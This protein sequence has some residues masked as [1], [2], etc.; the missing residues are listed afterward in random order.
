MNSKNHPRQLC[1]LH[2]EDNENDHLLVVEALRA[3][4]LN[5]KF[6]LAKSKDE[7]TEAL[8]TAK[9]DLI[10]SDYALPSYDGASALS[11]ARSTQP[12]T[13]F[14]FLSG[15][16]GEEVAV[17]SLK[18]GA[19][20]YVLKQRPVRLIAAIHQALQNAAERVRLNQAEAVIR[21]QG[22]LLDKAQDAII[23][24][25]LE[26][27][28]IYWNQGA[29]RVY[30][31]SAAEA[32][33]KDL[34]D[35]LFHGD[36][37]PEA[38]D[39]AKHMDKGDEWTGE[40]PEFTKDGRTV[41]VQARATLIRD[42]QGRPK[43]LLIINTDITEKKN[44]EIQLLRSQR[45][46]SL[47]ALAG[48][49]AHD[50]NNALTPIIIG[51]QLLKENKSGVEQEK[52]LDMICASANRGAGMVRQILS[53]ARGSKSQTKQI[54][55]RQLIN[56]MIRIIRNTFPKS[57]L[58]SVRM[59]GGLWNVSGDVTELHQVIL[60]LCVNARDAMPQGGTLTLHAENQ[61]LNLETKSPPADMRPGSYVMLA[62]ADTGTGI[63]PEVLPRIFEPFFSTK[64]PDRGTGLGLSTVASIVKHHN[65]FIQVHSEVGHGTEFKIY[66]P[67]LPATE[68][69]SPPSETILPV[70]HGELIL[71]MDDEATVR[72][73]TKTTLENYGYQ[74]VTAISGLDG[75]TLFQE[76][77][78]EIKLL[79]S[80]TD[81]P[82]MSG[83]AALHIIQK[84][85]PEIPMI[86][87]S[88]GKQDPASYKQINATHLT[89]LDKPYTVEQL[90]QTVAR[91]LN[92]VQA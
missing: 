59:G 14:I 42:E 56:E 75:L 25:N 8:R 41:I 43:S 39:A 17:D 18:N 53:F 16:I 72:Q 89:V 35:L 24:C 45:M 5:C 78:Q 2:L 63:P 86:I 84:L 38:Q 92:S 67:A 48:G 37:P 79:V 34:R 65:G 82:I 46:D 58:T 49:I 70:G 27:L 50:L 81:M 26:R 87:A 71:V 1:V 47:G 44:Y 21:E 10:I 77:R 64:T 51:A 36:I 90:L 11:L 55:V 20:D 28:I 30:G 6:T 23:V 7:F 69:A 32:A 33:G 15:T 4:G 29:E 9:Y 57:I 76:Y 91:A 73:M 60:N 88:G 85:E 40:L 12:E 61:T 13:P 62:V 54:P 80:D 66:L 52:I 19:T 83:L 68:P 22:A 3:D 31:W 74:V